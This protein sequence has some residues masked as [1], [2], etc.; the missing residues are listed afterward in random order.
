MTTS[1]SRHGRDRRRYG[2]RARLGLAVAC[3]L[4]ALVCRLPPNEAIDREVSEFARSCDAIT[5]LTGKEPSVAYDRWGTHRRMWPGDGSGEVRTY[6]YDMRGP[7]G[8][9]RLWIKAKERPNGEWLIVS[10][11]GQLP[12]EIGIAISR[13][14]GR[15]GSPPNQ[16]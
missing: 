13:C 9:V 5:S 15:T 1:S 7:L 4:G 11:D 8:A 2:A 12:H 16:E 14:V 10:A 3:V 6:T